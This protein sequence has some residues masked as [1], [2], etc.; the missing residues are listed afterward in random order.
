MTPRDQNLAKLTKWIA[1]MRVNAAKQDDPEGYLM[2]WHDELGALMSHL[3][4]EATELV[5][6]NAFDLADAQIQLIRPLEDA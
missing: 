6:L 2:A 4:S 1:A 5:G 3:P